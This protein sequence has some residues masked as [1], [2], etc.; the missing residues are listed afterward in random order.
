MKLRVA[1]LQGGRSGEHEI[2]LRSARSITEAMD[3]SRYEVVPFTIDKEG[4][5]SPRPILPE[6][7]A[8]PGIDVV[9]PALHGTFGEDGTVQGLLELADLPYVGAGVLSSSVSM[10]KELMKR[11]C[12]ER[13]LPVVDYTVAWRDA[14]PDPPSFGFPMFVKPANLGSSVGISKAHN[15]V[16]L[17][18]ALTLAAQ[19][20]RKVIIERATLGQELECA[21]LGNAD[22]VACQPA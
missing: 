9:F 1:V 14:N 12:R 22:P 18:A 10:D 5:W 2:S 15:P 20:D 4:K 8:N 17:E 11:I 6:P 13:C 19:F 3:A 21:V 16:E 7:G